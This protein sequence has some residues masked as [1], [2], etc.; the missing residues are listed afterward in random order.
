MLDAL[1][2]NAFGILADD[3]VTTTPTT[4]TVV[5]AAGEVLVRQQQ[6]QQKHNAMDGDGTGG[7]QRINEFQWSGTWQAHNNVLNSACS[8]S[9]VS[10]KAHHQSLRRAATV[11]AA[12][13]L[14]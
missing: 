14:I 12:M 4:M 9:G 8:I 13:H 1:N 10:A 7:E 11:A 6:Q 5:A 2:A 3:A